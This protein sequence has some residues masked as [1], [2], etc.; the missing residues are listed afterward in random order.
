MTAVLH[1]NLRETP[2]RAAAGEGCWL[3]DADGKRYL[4]ASGGAAVSCLGHSHPEVVAAVQRQVAELP[5]AHSSFFTS[6]PA[7]ELADHLIAHAP[8]GFGAGRAA[9]VGSGS[10]AM[11]VAL[12]LARQYFVERGE[13]DRSRFI[14]RRMSYHG[15]T[16][17]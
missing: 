2:R 15:N 1:R 5:Y 6:G 12:K 10:E 7:E 17:G 11:E 8:A 9:F 13:P 16:L 3:I 4:D 14:A